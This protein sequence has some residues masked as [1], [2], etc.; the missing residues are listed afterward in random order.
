MSKSGQK[1]ASVIR[2]S[3]TFR[4]TKPSGT[5]GGG[6]QVRFQ[7]TKETY[8]L[9]SEGVTKLEVVLTF[10]LES[11][12]IDGMSKGGQKQTSVVY[13]AHLPRFGPLNRRGPW[14]VTGKF[15]FNLLKEGWKK[16]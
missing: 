6:G 15:D 5:M 1:Q 9:I 13:R 3:S 16:K 7:S 11:N 8:E 4:S 12:L 10:E 2:A 14:V